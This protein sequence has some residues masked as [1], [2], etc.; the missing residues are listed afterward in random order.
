[1]AVFPGGMPLLLSPHNAAFSVVSIMTGTGYVSSDYGQWETFLFGFCFSDLRR[2]L[3]RLQGM[4]DEGISV[5]DSFRGLRC[6][7]NKI[8]T[9]HAVMQTRYNGGK[10]N[11][12]VLTSITGISLVRYISCRPIHGTDPSRSGLRDRAV[13][14]RHK[15]VKRRP[16]AWLDRW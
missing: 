14:C 3:C 13:Q 7:I 9:P 6:Q 1:M 5:S 4:Q 10:V 16:R 15:F 2:W 11:D 12:E 8:V